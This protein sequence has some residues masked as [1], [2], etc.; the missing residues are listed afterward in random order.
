MRVQGAGVITEAS[1]FVHQLVSG[2]RCPCRVG[3]RPGAEPAGCGTARVRYPIV[4]KVHFTCNLWE[5]FT[6][7]VLA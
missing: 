5:Q 1:R 7:W 6:K 2:R 3:Y 4:R